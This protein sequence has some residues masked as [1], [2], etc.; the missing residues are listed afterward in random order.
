VEFLS[1]ILGYRA[2]QSPGNVILSK[3]QQLT[4]SG[5]QLISGA[6]GNA[7]EPILERYIGQYVVLD[8]LVDGKME[9]EHGILKEYSAQY[10]ELL[11]VKLEVPLR[12]YLQ[13]RPP[14]APAPVLVERVGN[15]MRVANELDRTVLVETVR[16]GDGS[17]ALNVAVEPGQSVEVELLPQETDPAEA[18]VEL[19]LGV[20]CLAD[21]IVPRSIAVVRHAGKREALSLDTLLG[22]DELP[23]LPW[24]KRL[25]GARVRRRQV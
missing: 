23:Q 25:I 17:R 9:E 20:R 7:Y 15:A 3:Y 16:Q 2:S 18:P 19:Q 6:V 12:I 22:L 13:D 11:S 14:P 4:T 10:I 1:A 8:I 24:L 5:A 21:L